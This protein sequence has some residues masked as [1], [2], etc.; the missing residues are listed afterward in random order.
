MICFYK[1]ALEFQF[2]KSGF[3][4]AKMAEPFPVRQVRSL[5]LSSEARIPSLQKLLLIF[6]CDTFYLVKQTYIQHLT[7]QIAYRSRA[8]LSNAPRGARKAPR[9][10]CL[11]AALGC[12][13]GAFSVLLAIAIPVRFCSSRPTAHCFSCSDRTEKNCFLLLF[14]SP[15]T[16]HCS[17]FTI[18]V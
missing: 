14:C 11:P 12:Q 10:A 16:N 7:K 13:R 9:R 2:G 5:A 15:F 17:L 4:G 3:Q 6:S 1:P 18:Q 8:P